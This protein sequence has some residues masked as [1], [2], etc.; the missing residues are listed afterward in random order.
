MKLFRISEE[1]LKAITLFLIEK[2]VIL[3]P[4]ISPMGTPDFSQYLD[5]GKEFVLIL[6]RNILVGILRL[7]NTGELRDKNSQ[8]IIGS[9]LLWA[10]FNNIT[11]TSGLAQTEYSDYKKSASESSEE[12]NVFAEIFNQ[13]HPQDWLDLALDRRQLVPKV[14]AGEENEYNFFTKGIHYK[15]HY[16]E[17]L[18][19]SQLYYSDGLS[20]SEKFEMFHQWVFDNILICKYTT[21]FAAQVFSNRSK[22]LRNNDLDLSGVY[23]NCT[24]QAWDI[25]YL[26]I[27]STKYYY[28]DSSDK[29]YLFSTLDKELRNLFIM[30]HTKSID[31]VYGDFFKKETA[32]KILAIVTGIY[33]RRKAPVI[34]NS[35]LDELIEQEEEK[36]RSIFEK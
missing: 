24:N 21:Y 14:K 19:I 16:L 29:I 31:S 13:Y 15:M 7:L 2:K 34:D 10:E 12:Q 25:T 35:Q 20:I 6:D 17:M 33:Q 36:L 1:D 32:K 28:E 11:I 26:S 23:K 5:K 9:L 8:K 27:W 4:V 3:H 22:M 30:T 18:K